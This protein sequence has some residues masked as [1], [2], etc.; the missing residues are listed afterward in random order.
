MKFVSFAA[1][2]LISVSSFA[3]SVMP[4]TNFNLSNVKINGAQTDYVATAVIDYQNNEIHVTVTHDQTCPP[5]R[6]C[7]MEYVQ[8]VANFSAP[9]VNVEGDCG[10][11]Y[12]HASIDQRPVDGLKVDIVL[13]DHRLRMCHDLRAEAVEV[14]ASVTHPRQNEASKYLL[15]N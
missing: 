6:L 7:T 1:V 8:P 15:T 2:M 5:D 14:K 4:F 11:N 9:I 3:R 13:A 12:Y 10:S